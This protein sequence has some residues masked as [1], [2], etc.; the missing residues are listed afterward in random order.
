[1]T[2]KDMLIR[3]CI[4]T[5]LSNWN[6]VRRKSNSRIVFTN[7]REIIYNHYDILCANCMVTSWFASKVYVMCMCRLPE[8][9]LSSYLLAV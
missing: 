6:L 3:S 1:M 5:V 8:C 2:S 9:I 7:D 4:L